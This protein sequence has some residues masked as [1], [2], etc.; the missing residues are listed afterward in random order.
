MRNEFRAF[1]ARCAQDAK[2]AKIIFA[3]SQRDRTTK[4]TVMPYGQKYSVLKL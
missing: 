4:Q 1:T 2:D 3:W